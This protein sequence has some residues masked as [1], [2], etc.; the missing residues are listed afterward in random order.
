MKYKLRTNK[1]KGTNRCKVFHGR[2][3]EWCRVKPTTTWQA[4]DGREQ[5]NNSEIP[6]ELKL[7]SRHPYTSAPRL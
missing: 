4:P 3:S 1:C 5:I 7:S 6:E 2:A